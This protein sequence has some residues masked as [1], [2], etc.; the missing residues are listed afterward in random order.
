MAKPM[1]LDYTIQ[2]RK[3]KENIIADAFSRCHEEGSLATITVVTLQWYE[4]VISS[5][6]GDQRIMAL[7]EKLIVG[8]GEMEGYT[9][10]EGRIVVGDKEERSCKPCMSRP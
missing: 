7:L 9:L 1:E 6:V 10:K 4:E 3:G 2:F 5:C 8:N